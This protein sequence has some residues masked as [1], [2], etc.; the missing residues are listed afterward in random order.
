MILDIGKNDTKFQGRD[1]LISDSINKKFGNMESKHTDV[2]GQIVKRKT[3][4]ST[5]VNFL[6]IKFDYVQ[7]DRSYSLGDRQGDKKVQ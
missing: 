3:G 4:S 6:N 2:T 5:N 1:L 7:Y